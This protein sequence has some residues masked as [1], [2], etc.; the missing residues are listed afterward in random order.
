MPSLLLTVNLLDGR[1]HGFDTKGRPEW[2]PSPARLFQ[3]LVAG[4]AKGA[5]LDEKDREALT[6]LEGLDSP[7][8]AAPAMTTGQDFKNFMPNN[9]LDVELPKK[10]HDWKIENAVAKIRAAKRHQPLVFNQEIPFFYIWQCKDDNN[11]A[12]RI[13]QIAKRL[14]QFGR[15]VDMAWASA[16]VLATEATNNRLA[17]YPGVIYRPGGSESA[18]T[19]ACPASGSL[20]SLIK[21]YE[22]NRNRITTILK[23]APTK[24]APN[25]KK[26]ADQV[27]T[28]PPRPHFRQISYNSPPGRLLYELRNMTADGNSYFSWPL[29]DC[30]R[31]VTTVR[32]NAAAKLKKQFPDKTSIIEQVFGL[33]RHA[34]EDDKARRLQ[35]IPLPSIGHQHADR[36]IRRLLVQI[37]T[38]CPLIE[39]DIAW[40]FA[41]P[42]DI[43][44]ATGEINW[45]LIK[46]TKQRKQRM[47]HHYK[48]Y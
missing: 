2:P 20:C 10:E 37:P 7:V 21:R 5:R 16:E 13:G 18:Y 39:G 14:Y 15:G 12:R 38:A 23:P 17:D 27:F 30:V 45:M 32:D 31:L 34:T 35:I 47:L 6:W 44:T 3:A 11:H 46:A 4:A 1:Y 33:C 9:D 29:K 41:M 43:D 42:Q 26:P 25:R 28:Q 19:L 36:A 22:K 8:I 40:A 48:V 24:K